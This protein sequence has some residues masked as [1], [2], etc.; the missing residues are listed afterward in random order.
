[1]GRGIF[2]MDIET[3]DILFKATFGNNDITTGTEQTYTS[4]KYCF[5][6]DPTIV[7]FSERRKVIYTADVYGQ[8]WKIDFNYDSPSQQWIVQRVFTSNPGYTLPSGSPNIASAVVNSNDSG[9]KAFY[10]PDVSY[11]GNDYTDNPVLYFGT[12][13][14][15]HPK[16][17][18]ISDRFYTIVDSNTL[19]NEGDLLNLTCDELD[20]DATAP[21][22]HDSADQMIQIQNNLKNLLLSGT[23]KGYYRI[24]DKQGDCPDG[25]DS[26]VGEKVLS[27]PTLFAKNIYFTTYQPILGEPCNPLGNAFIYALDYSY[28]TAAFNY[29]TTNDDYDGQILNLE[30]SFRKI[31][32]SSIPSGVRVIMREGEA[33]GLVSAGGN[34]I[35]AGEDGS[36]AI[37]GPPGGVSRL[38]W[39]TE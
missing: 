13:D 35:G 22:G 4:M 1:M 15:E 18:M 25:L 7:S 20:V 2:V 12:G 30:D 29:D 32:G 26:H 31:E 27:K 28:G 16:S 36:T 37:P 14:R 9:R 21:A 5:P 10:S 19:L 39:K 3:G 38:I 33:A 6:A 17:T 11:Y 23:A 8:I 24:L 34:I